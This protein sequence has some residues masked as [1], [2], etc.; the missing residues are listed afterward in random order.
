MAGSGNGDGVAL[1][2]T[3]SVGDGALSIC[4]SVREFPRILEIYMLFMAFPTAEYTI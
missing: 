4:R 2:L 3:R 1:L